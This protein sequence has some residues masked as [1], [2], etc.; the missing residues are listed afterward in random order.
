MVAVKAA[1]LA[2]DRVARVVF[3]DALAFLPGEK[4]ADVVRR[5][6]TPEVTALTIGVTRADVENR[7]FKDLDPS[8]RVWAA[9]RIT[10]HPIEALEG[11]MPATTFW[12]QR[13]T[14]TVIR[15]T[16]AAN[17]PE[18]HQRRTAE[19]LGAPYH[20][21]RTGHYPMLSM[22]DELTKLLA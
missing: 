15:C 5:A 7:M 19:K 9:D 2:R 17:P 12:D 22:P 1:E 21:M 18:A 11:P 8:L 3:V 4:V 13:W 14:A 6:A 16:L 10:P 20:E